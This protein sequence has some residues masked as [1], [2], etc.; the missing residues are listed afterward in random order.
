MHTL[1]SV[2][3]WTACTIEVSIAI[4]HEDILHVMHLFVHTRVCYLAVLVCW[5]VCQRRLDSIW[6]FARRRNPFGNHKLEGIA[7]PL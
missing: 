3:D 4:A 2:L 7:L 6:Q 1:R 5:I